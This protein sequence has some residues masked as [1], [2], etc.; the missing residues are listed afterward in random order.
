MVEALAEIEV[1]QED[2]L[3]VGAPQGI[4]MMNAIKT[5]E[6]RLT[7]G[8]FKHAASPMMAWCVGNLKIESTAT[9][10]RATKQNAGDAK[11]DPVM[12]MF[13]AVTV[14]VRNPEARGAGLNDY[15]NSLAG[16]A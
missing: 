1:T 10:I 11:I 16:A 9:A 12:A 2:G 5:T 6:R 3:L 7:N 13:N 14:M 8:T 4:M 15:L